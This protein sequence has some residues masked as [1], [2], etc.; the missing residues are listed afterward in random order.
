MRYFQMFEY[1]DLNLATADKVVYKFASTS[2]S[3][4]YSIFNTQY[5]VPSSQFNSYLEPIL[6]LAVAQFRDLHKW[7][8]IYSFTS[9]PSTQGSNCPR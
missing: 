1:C 9:P 6:N 3:H 8:F 7:T 5:S 2:T 4:Q